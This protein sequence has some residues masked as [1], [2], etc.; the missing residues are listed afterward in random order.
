MTDEAAPLLDA[1]QVADLVALDK[2]KGA[3]FAQFVDLFVSG[4][5]ERI[6]RLRILSA[7]G[8]AAALADAAHAL[9]GAAGN[10]GA[11]RFVGILEHLETAAKARDAAGVTKS[12][13]LLDAAYAATRSALLAATGRMPPDS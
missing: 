9:R 10:V 2:G 7:S 3:V 12:A 6:A 1:M 11:V 8:D 4:T 5:G 13:A